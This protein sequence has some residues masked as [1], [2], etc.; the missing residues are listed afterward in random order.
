MDKKYKVQIKYIK[1]KTFLNI[2]C[3]NNKNKNC[4]Y[5]I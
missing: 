3:L 4:N 1:K 2:N 5:I